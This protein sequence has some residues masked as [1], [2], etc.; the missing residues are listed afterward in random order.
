MDWLTGG[1]TILA[2]ELI[3]RRKWYGWAVA[4]ANQALWFYVVVYG[5]EMWGFLPLTAVLTWRYTVALSRWRAGVS[6]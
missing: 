1:I 3:A 2:M 5:K 4:L 6:A